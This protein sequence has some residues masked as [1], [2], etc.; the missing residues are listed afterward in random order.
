MT[1]DRAVVDDREILY[2]NAEAAL[3]QAVQLDLNAE[4]AFVT[5][6]SATLEGEYRATR[7]NL[8]LSI[9]ELNDA[10]YARLFGAATMAQFAKA[11]MDSLELDMQTI[12][13][14]SASNNTL[15]REVLA[16]LDQAHTVEA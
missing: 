3:K 13:A 14:S 10:Q 11:V 6:P 15:L 1:E 16:K 5:N 2:R 4:V 7:T 8:A 12:K 9:A